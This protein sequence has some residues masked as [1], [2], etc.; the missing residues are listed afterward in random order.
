VARPLSSPA[1]RLA[2]GVVAWRAAVLGAVGA[3][4]LVP[5]WASPVL[6][7]TDGP[8]HLYNAA[9]AEAV[10]AARPPFATTYRVPHATLRAN[11]AS[12]LLLVVLGR[13]VG[14][15]RAERIVLSAAMVGNFVLLLWLTGGSRG[16]AF[17]PVVAW[18]SHSW[19]AW[20]GFYD[21]VLSVAGYALL[22]GLLAHPVPQ[23]RRDL[24]ILGVLLLL[25]FTHFFTFLVGTGLV[26]AVVAWRAR[27]RQASWSQLGAVAPA[28]LLLLIEMASGGAGGAGGS[29]LTWQPPWKALA[30]LVLGDV[31][32]SFQPLDVVGGVAIMAAVWATLFVRVRALRDGVEPLTPLEAV[33]FGLLALS[34][35]APFAVGVGGYVPIRLQL[36]GVVTLLPSVA[37][38]LPRLPDRP[39]R[40]IAVVALAGFALHAAS[41][42]RTASVVNRDL[43]AI[44]TLLVR[45]GAGPGSWVRQRFTDSR[46]GLFRIG[47]Y[48]HLVERLALRHDLIVLDDYEALYGVFDISWQARP[49]WLA[50]AR[51]REDSLELRLV[52]GDVSWGGGLYLVHERARRLGSSDARLEVGP[53]LGDADFAV[54]RVRR[55]G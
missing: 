20:M 52:P 48:R 18:L 42:I 14:W 47:A 40:W 12:E 39:V 4:V 32:T 22:V 21:F 49:D 44:D 13:S 11:Q 45:S 24:L 9:V 41:I 36:L 53:T 6:V 5:V 19:F 37:A 31:V 8:S 23:R 28:V 33:G 55:R 34:V 43:V 7:T 3:L 29:A 51:P 2:A 50:I 26:A 10:A 46:R 38:A 54:T 27:R 30:G 25:Y 1:G 35:V 16:L 17:T 15:E